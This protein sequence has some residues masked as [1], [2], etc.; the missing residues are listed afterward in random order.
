MSSRHVLAAGLL[1]AAAALFG[2]AAWMRTKAAVAS[3]LI[4]RSLE[5]ALRDGRPHRPWSWADFHP[6]ARLRVPRLGV[7][8]PVLSG[9]GGSALAFGLGRI[10][11]TSTAI[12]GHRDTWAAFLR[13]VEAGD[14]VL[15]EA[16]DGTRAYR[17][18]SIRVV[19]EDAVEVLDPT[20]R[21]RLTLVTCWPFDGLVRSPLRVV[22]EC[23]PIAGAF[24]RPGSDLSSRPGSPPAASSPRP[25]ASSTATAPPT[26]R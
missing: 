20:P 19:P 10:Q 17:V 16:A 25:A 5:T 22:F 12:A 11:G 14:T 7:S 4:E 6:V 23:D 15:L 24:S 3:V 2:Q 21:E 9:A 1:L 13:E 18:A 8:Q 26:P